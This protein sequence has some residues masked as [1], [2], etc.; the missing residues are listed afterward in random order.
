MNLIIPG[1]RL[2]RVYSPG[3]TI[4]YD[5]P[6][7]LPIITEQPQDITVA[8]GVPAV[9]TITAEKADSYQWRGDGVDIPGENSNILTIAAPLFDDNGLLISCEV[10]NR[11]GCVISEDALLT[12]TL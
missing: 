2:N 5:T 6:R 1:Q 10:C 3:D 9:F 11:W 8:Q 7:T 4:A 12:V